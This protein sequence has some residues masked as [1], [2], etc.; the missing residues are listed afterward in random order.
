MRKEYAFWILSI[1]G[2]CAI[3]SSTMS[4]NPVLPLFAQYLGAGEQYIGV[5]SAASTIPGILISMPAGV[6]SDMYGRK[7]LLQIALFIFASAPFGYLCVQELW[8]LTLVRFYH[9]MATAIFGPVALAAVAERYIEDR[10]A[11][12]GLYSSATMVGRMIAPVAGGF[13][14]TIGSFSSVYSACAVGGIVA[15]LLSFFLTPSSSSSSSSSSSEHR[16]VNSAVRD[17]ITDKRIMITN[18]VEACQYFAFGGFETFLPLYAYSMGITTSE[19][20]FIFSMQLIITMLTKPTMGTLSDKKGRIPVII[21]GLFMGAVSLIM[22]S[23]GNNLLGLALVASGFG[24]GMATV[25]ASTSAL[26]SDLS[27]GAHGSALGVLSMIMDVGHAS[28]PVVTGMIIAA[29]G[30][31]TAF[32]SI[33]LLLICA[34]VLFYVTHLFSSY[35]NR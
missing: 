1:V 29:W 32:R 34:G 21:L 4:K 18:G 24:L 27:R 8:Q 13:L 33:A 5:I 6:L 28:G 14:L 11:R 20:G 35:I 12:L 10:G 16:P 2:G 15:F 7:R 9:G 23:Y 17:L 3:F 31:H 19:I 25:T 22:I 26:V 30:Y